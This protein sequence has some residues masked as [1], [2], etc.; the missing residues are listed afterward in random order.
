MD[1]ATVQR[2]FE[3]FFTTKAVGKGTGLGLSVVHGIMKAHQGAVAVESKPGHG[4]TFHLFFPAAHAVDSA[5]ATGSDQTSTLTKS[6][7][8][9]RILFI[10]DEPSMAILV[11]RLLGKLGYKV[12]SHT[13]PATALAAFNAEPAA[14]DLII[15]DLSMPGM[16]GLEVARAMLAQRPEAS[17]ILA[18]GHL[19][20]EELEQARNL[21]IRDVILKPNTADDLGPMVQRLLRH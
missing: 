20:P 17:V 4:A 19:R 2:V 1:Q 15:T 3:P 13:S 16:S 11:E 9:Q 10:D 8:G 5:P 21:G 6:G 18:S 12:S 7:A 14:F